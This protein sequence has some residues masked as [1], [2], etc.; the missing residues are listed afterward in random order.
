MQYC[1]PRVCALSGFGYGEE[2]A[3][4]KHMFAKKLAEDM[5]SVADA[6]AAPPPPPKAT[7][8]T[9]T[10]PNAA[11]SNAAPRSVRSSPLMPPPTGSSNGSS[12][13]SGLRADAS[14]PS[15]DSPPMT[16]QS[17]GSSVDSD[18]DRFLP[19][20][21]DLT[22]TN[23]KKLRKRPPRKFFKSSDPNMPRNP[24]HLSFYTAPTLHFIGYDIQD[25]YKQ[26]ALHLLQNVPSPQCGEISSRYDV[27]EVI[28]TPC[29]LH[30]QDITTVKTISNCS[31]Q[32][33]DKHSLIMTTATV[34]KIFALK[35]LE[36]ALV[37]SMP[38]LIADAL[39]TMTLIGELKANMHIKY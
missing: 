20:Q 16:Q 19:S 4:Y 10:P 35:L 26:R 38:I 39:G 18:T 21:H 22:P 28:Q 9:A 14:S 34:N 29:S 24:L 15:T 2:L 1:L 6:K 17:T 5:R 33:L 30:T 12:V 31:G 3:F 8:P 27:P 37:H 11:P 13:E 7:P 23:K 36:I 32:P 25:T